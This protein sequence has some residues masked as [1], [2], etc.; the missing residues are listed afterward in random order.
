MGQ[1]GIEKVSACIF[2]YNSH[3]RIDRTYK[4]EFKLDVGASFIIW[5]NN[6]CIHIPKTLQSLSWKLLKF[7]ELG[8]N[9]KKK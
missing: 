2:L 6:I 8:E 9:G 5:R 3:L 1:C 7:F 4:V